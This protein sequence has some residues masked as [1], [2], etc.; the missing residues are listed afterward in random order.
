[1]SEFKNLTETAQLQAIAYSAYFNFEKEFWTDADIGNAYYGIKALRE[2]GAPRMGIPN[3]WLKT[4]DFRVAR[5]VYRMPEVP[6]EYRDRFPIITGVGKIE[7]EPT[8]EEA[9]PEEQPAQEA[10]PKK[11]RAKKTRAKKNVTKTKVVDET[12]T[13]TVDEDVDE[14]ALSKILQEAGI[15]T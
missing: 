6:V 8:K 9:K 7:E 1:M 5:G 13:E 15:E 12:P 11:T 3:S 10:K 14:E 4:E 2:Q